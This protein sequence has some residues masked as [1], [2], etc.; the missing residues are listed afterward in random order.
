MN[1]PSCGTQVQP[2]DSFCMQ[3]GALLGNAA[4][5]HP[6]TAAE[7]TA[8][9]P[10]PQPLPPV[11]DPGNPPPSKGRWLGLLA[12][13]LVL[14]GLAAAGGYLLQQTV[15]HKDQ[16][17][18]VAASEP[19]LYPA[20]PPQ[21]ALDSGQPGTAPPA[22]DSAAAEPLPPGTPAGGTLDSGGAPAGPG[23][24]DSSP[25]GGAPG[26]GPAAGLTGGQPAG[27][28]PSAPPNPTAAPSVPKPSPK[29][30]EPP[31]PSPVQKPP[32]AAPPAA[33]PTSSGG[34]A[35]PTPTAQPP[36]VD[37]TQQ[38]PPPA[39]NPTVAAAVPQPAP[40][41]LSGPGQTT[42]DPA[43]TPQGQ[44]APRNTRVLQ[45]DGS[46]PPPEHIAKPTASGAPGATA[47][48]AAPQEGIIYWT[49]RLT[50]N[51]VIV[52]DLNKASIGTTDGGLPATP[53]DVWVPSPAVVLVERPSSKNNW[54]RLS[55][56]C[57]QSTNRS[58]TLNVQW[59]RLR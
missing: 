1:C 59:K 30:K 57:L 11:I 39:P 31:R 10:D 54:S 48:A 33:R 46:P 58:V 15:F 50:K 3:C 19:S 26:G 6:V 34:V 28:P 55:F 18:A 42:A 16:P 43:A 23:S 21:A 36:R 7:S 13:L 47:A 41:Q 24:A 20:S 29:P 9:P 5:P 56:R 35:S 44:R 4:P 2:G 14:F 53:V 49:G 45:P 32:Q 27:G 38:A 52:I 40:P 37:T 51:Q 22:V 25:P 12:L 17:P 8:R